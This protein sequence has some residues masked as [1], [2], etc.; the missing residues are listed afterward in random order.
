MSKN[1]NLYKK[2]LKAHLTLIDL[3]VV[4][5]KDILAL[6]PMVFWLIS[7]FAIISFALVDTVAD[8]YL[9]EFVSLILGNVDL[10]NDITYHQAVDIIKNFW[11]TV[12]FLYAISKFLPIINKR[13]RV[14]TAFN[15]FISSLLTLIAYF[16]ASYEF[17]DLVI[18][19]YVIC[20]VAILV[21]LILKYLFDWIYFRAV[22]KIKSLKIIK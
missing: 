14:V 15:I 7:I 1:A 6:W 19:A 20:L 22:K 13:Y 11:F 4:I 10:S 3:F 12:W 21:H 9:A 17:R 16:R 5:T 2:I 18:T 8:P